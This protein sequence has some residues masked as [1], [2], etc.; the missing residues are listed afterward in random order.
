MSDVLL[1]GG[2]GLL[3]CNIAGELLRAG[4]TVRALVRSLERGRARLPEPCELTRGDVTDKTS[5]RRAIRGC[6]VVYHA[7][8]LPEQWA[9]EPRIFEEVNVGGTRNLIE[10]A[11]EAGVER[12]VYTST[13]DVF[14]IEAGVPFDEHRIDPHPKATAYERSKQAADRLVA[15][16]LEEGLPA[17]FLHPAGIYGPGPTGSPGLNGFFADLLNGRIPMLLPGSVP[18]VFARDAALGHLL[19]ESASCGSR[20]I[21]SESRHELAN[22]A[23]LTCELDG[24]RRVPP[25]M[26]WAVA[27]AVSVV[28]EA[29]SSFTGRPPLIP[30]GQLHFL[31]CGATPDASHA[32]HDL[33]WR[34]IP[35][36]EG[37][38]HT[39]AFLRQSGRIADPAVTA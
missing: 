7:S 33:G 39:L 21:L 29:L 31:G 20:Y 5:L 14:T 25:I 36:A 10:V 37:L 23:R 22:L 34:P 19:A 18:V 30:A 15:E 2:T 24:H 9:A 28:G 38:R 35:V 32:R 17:V 27:K 16:A 1:T 11:L 3:G 8:G 13:I 26:P 12:F 4:R 6:S